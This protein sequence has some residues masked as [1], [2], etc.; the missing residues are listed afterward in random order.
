M[1]QVHFKILKYDYFFVITCLHFLH[2]SR[3]SNHYQPKTDL[4]MYIKIL[5][6]FLIDCCVN[7]IDYTAY[8]FISKCF[9]YTITQLFAYYLFLFSHTRLSLT[10]RTICIYPLIYRQINQ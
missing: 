1:K 3:W 7:F 9:S 2:Y 5:F 6:L 10:D 8:F 4:Y